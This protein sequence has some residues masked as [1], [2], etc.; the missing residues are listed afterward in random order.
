MSLREKWLAVF[1]RKSTSRFIGAVVTAG[2]L[3]ATATAEPPVLGAQPQAAPPCDIVEFESDLDLSVVMEA[4]KFCQDA[5]GLSDAQRDQLAMVQGAYV[6]GLVRRAAHRF[7]LEAALMVLL[8]VDSEDPGR[9]VDVAAAEVRIRELERMTTD[10]HIA[11]LRAVEASKAILT[12]AQRATL[13]TLLDPAR[14][15]ATPRLDL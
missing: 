4:L 7:L 1:G 15:A 3:T 8:R 12:P 9:P 2:V 14:G 13:A 5:L 6:D 11:T 10:D